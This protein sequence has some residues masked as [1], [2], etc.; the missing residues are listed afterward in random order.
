[1]G[2]SVLA[3]AAQDAGDTLL[4]WAEQFADHPIVPRKGGLHFAFYGRVSTEDHQ[5]PVTSRARQQ[6][7]AAALVRGHGRI[8]AEFFDAGQSRVLP[9]ARR[10]ETAAL[11]AAMADPDRDFDAIVVGNMS[12][13]FTAT[14]AA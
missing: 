13:R 3:E 5:D 6:N 9:W 2:A 10:P 14:S 7:Q 1:V 11:M 4:A 12:G 8:V